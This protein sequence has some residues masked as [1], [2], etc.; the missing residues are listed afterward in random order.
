MLLTVSGNFFSILLFYQ[1]APFGIKE[2]NILD[3]NR[4]KIDKIYRVTFW[5]FDLKEI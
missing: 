4:R 2:G 5:L 3:A 1:Y